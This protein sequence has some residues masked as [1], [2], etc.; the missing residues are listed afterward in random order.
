[1]Q[2]LVFIIAM[3]SIAVAFEVLLL[4][5]TGLRNKL[6]ERSPRLLSIMFS[7]DFCLCFWSS[8]VTCFI[9]FL[10][11]GLPIVW[12]VPIFSTVI[13]RRLL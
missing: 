10:L 6:I 8:V 2:T 13:A 1:M 12:I 9:L 11:L 7:C 3:V 4:E 5:Q